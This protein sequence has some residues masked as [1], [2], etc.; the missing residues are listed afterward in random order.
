[1]IYLTPG[2]PPRVRLVGRGPHGPQG[3]PGAD[4]A[5]DEDTLR[6]EL[7]EHGIEGYGAVLFQAL[8]PA[9]DVRKVYDQMRAAT[10]AQ[11]PPAPLH[12]RLFIETGNDAAKYHA[13]HWEYLFD[14]DRQSFLAGDPLTPFSRFLPNKDA[15]PL[16]PKIQEL[17]VLFAIADPSDLGD[18]LSPDPLHHLPRLE[19]APALHAVKSAVTA[20]QGL[21]AKQGI[22]LAYE[23]LPSASPAAA[24]VTLKAL[25]D[26]LAEGYHVLHLIAH[27]RRMVNGYELV[28]EDENRRAR[29]HTAESFAHEIEPGYQIQLVFLASCQS[30]QPIAAD[31]YEG[32]AAK[33]VVR[34]VPAVI[35]MTQKV[36]FETTYAF[37]QLFYSHLAYHGVVDR[38][39]N[40]ARRSMYAGDDW[41]QVR[42]DR[43]W[44]VPL[45]FLR[46]EDGRLFRTDAKPETLSTPRFTVRPLKGR[47][48]RAAGP[49]PVLAP[50][51]KEPRLNP[52]TIIGKLFGLPQATLPSLAAAAASKHVILIGPPGT[53][54]T[55]LAENL[56]RS[57]CQGNS[58]RGLVSVTAS[59]DWTT[60]DTIGG[61]M[62]TEAGPLVFR[63][64][65][66]LRA[67]RA[68]RWLL[69][70]E[71]NRADIDK[72]F[73]ELFTVL[74]GQGVTLPYEMDGRPVRI[75][76]PGEVAESDSDY[77]LHPAWR[78]LG[79]MNVYD[80]ASL[81]ALSSAFMRRFAFVDVPVPEP[82]LY[83]KLIDDFL[84][85]H[86]L[87]RQ[88]RPGLADRIKALF[89]PK[90]P[91][92]WPL[93][94][95]RCLGPAIAKD[96]IAYLALRLMPAGEQLPDEQQALAEAF[97]LLAAAQL[98]G[99]DHDAITAIYGSLRHGFGDR[100]DL[101]GA[102][103]RDLYPHI[104]LQDWPGTYGPGKKE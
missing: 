77:V 86:P 5:L 76:P 36:S 43:D 60:F 31:A 9:G 4:F 100:A 96:M 58:C 39:L 61:Y 16:P 88:N 46:S 45:L 55:T 62:P 53:G 28:L 98:D 15:L 94:R 11:V 93:L 32:L 95:Y 84:E 40:A 81:F 2:N 65:I 59:A 27:G 41:N 79:T 29:P 90:D 69:I 68:E 52:H 44:A 78:I 82:A 25:H 38:A 57:A 12:V 83:E 24:P 91:G 33:V 30:G 72:A 49:P 97:N 104:P 17:K 63:P 35:A 56:A 74:S 87:L 73:G 37:T 26:K 21:L 3:E 102:R 54:K 34:N 99:L 80:K 85:G 14:P 48:A 66:F 22:T 7:T 1:M 103:L 10:Q 18:P 13:Y 64:G 20:L 70:D 75:L 6:N 23:I 47:A 42:E 101:V 50:L 8:F 89:A 71:I 92:P 19:V 51:E 67:I